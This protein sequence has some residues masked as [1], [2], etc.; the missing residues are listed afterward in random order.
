MKPS[1][2]ERSPAAVVRF[3][4]EIAEASLKL[5]A[6]PA[7]PC[8]VCGFLGEIA[9]ASLKPRSSACAF[10]SVPGFLGEIAEAYHGSIKWG[11]VSGAS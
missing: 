5:A 7:C 6:L 11:T 9:E 8:A 10:K 1:Q 4:G 3:L 2:P